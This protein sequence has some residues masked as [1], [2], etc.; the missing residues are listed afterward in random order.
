MCDVDLLDR[1]DRV[2]ELGRLVS[3]L[4]IA[5]YTLLRALTAHLIQVVQH[6]D[7]NKMTMRNVSIVFSPT[8]GIPGTIFNLLMSEFDY[9]FWT[10]E[11][12][13][14]APRMILDDENTVYETPTKVMEDDPPAIVAY[15]QP[16]PP[17]TLVTA[18]TAEEEL[19]CASAT[20]PP[21]NKLGR[22][23]TLQLKDGR[24]N[25]NSVN[26]REAAPNTIVELEKQHHHHNHHHGK[27]SGLAGVTW[28]DASLFVVLGHIGQLML[29][30]IEDE[31]NDLALT[32]DDY[33]IVSSDDKLQATAITI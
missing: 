2:N 13:D 21:S 4:P 18:A 22:K 27:R 33:S 5:N 25:R 3:L 28:A 32:D 29:D 7:V 31:V 14:A 11:D 26:Y 20:E 1:K 16:C 10:T 17:T 30:E 24:S 15:D 6:S 12:G 19:E 23:P 8:L 9:I